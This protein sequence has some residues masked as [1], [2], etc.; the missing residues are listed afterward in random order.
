MEV[1]KEISEMA[2][3]MRAD[4]SSRRLTVVLVYDVWTDNTAARTVMEQNPKW[5]REFCA[6]YS[7]SRRRGWN[8]ANARRRTFIKR[9]GTLR[10]L[11]EIAAGLCKTVYANR[12]LPYIEE[13]IR[14]LPKTEYVIE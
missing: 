14:V 12:L 3:L 2:E 11:A 5:Y 9:Q 8:W 13:Q 10:A 6:H 1:T 4:L 7:P